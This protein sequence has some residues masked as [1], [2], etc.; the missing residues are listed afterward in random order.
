MS[1]VIRLLKRLL[2]SVR[3]QQTYTKNLVS[4]IVCFTQLNYALTLKTFVLPSILVHKSVHPIC[5]SYTHHKS[6]RVTSHRLFRANI[7]KESKRIEITGQMAQPAP[8]WLIPL[9]NNML[10]IYDQHNH[11]LLYAAT[12][13][14]S[15]W[16]KSNQSSTV[17]LLTLSWGN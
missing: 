8:H 10:W 1:V 4:W 14:H 11:T 2:R 9:V 7:R 16:Q 12:F 13:S 3:L 6:Y 17:F 5:N 15:S